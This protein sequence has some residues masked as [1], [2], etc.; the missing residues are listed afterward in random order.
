MTLRKFN[1]L[2]STWI[3]IQGYQNRKREVYIFNNKNIKLHLGT[4]RYKV[5]STI[6]QHAD[7]LLNQGC[8]QRGFVLVLCT[9]VNRYGAGG[10]DTAPLET[11]IFTIFRMTLLIILWV[12]VTFFGI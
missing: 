10:G 11:T 5:Y 8:T 12:F 2:D 6:K 3:S 1:F 4:L 7:R 9:Q